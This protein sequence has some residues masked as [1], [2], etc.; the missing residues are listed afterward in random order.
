MSH[1]GE[2]EMFPLL[3]VHCSFHL[4]EPDAISYGSF[5]CCKLIS[6]LSWGF[7]GIHRCFQMGTCFFYSLNK[8]GNYRDSLGSRYQCGN[9]KGSPC[10]YSQKYN[11]FQGTT[12]SKMPEVL[13][14]QH[15]SLQ[16]Q[17]EMLR[18]SRAQS[19]ASD[20]HGRTVKLSIIKSGVYYIYY[21]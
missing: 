5:Y 3:W 12:L 8:T 7:S 1:K 9:T 19:T 15:F 21:Y 14:T 13:K 6:Y 18:C 16:T 4:V 17:I 2:K 11:L 10:S 20:T